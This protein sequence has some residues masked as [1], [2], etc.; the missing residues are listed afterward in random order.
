MTR[1]IDTNVASKIRRGRLSM[2]VN[3][4]SI[5]SVAASELLLI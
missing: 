4:A 3:G 5:S 1:L 2:S